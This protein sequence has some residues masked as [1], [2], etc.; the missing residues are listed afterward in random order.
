MEEKLER[1]QGRDLS[2]T[3]SWKEDIWEG[4]KIIWRENDLG[5]IKGFL[6]EGFRSLEKDIVYEKNDLAR[7]TF[8]KE[9]I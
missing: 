3:Y 1:K 6:K 4:K 7:K 9:T 8:R 5:R 2:R